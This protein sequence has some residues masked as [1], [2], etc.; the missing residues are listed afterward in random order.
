MIGTSTQINYRQTYFVTYFMGRKVSHLRTIA[1]YLQTGYGPYVPDGIR[2]SFQRSTVIARTHAPSYSRNFYMMMNDD[3]RHHLYNHRKV[4]Y[5][6]L[7]ASF[8][9]ADAVAPF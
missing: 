7:P 2:T 9:P 4:S 6:P 1:T 5:V 8:I 3:A